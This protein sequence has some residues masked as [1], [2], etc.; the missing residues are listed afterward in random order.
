MKGKNSTLNKKDQLLEQITSSINDKYS[1]FFSS[2]KFYYAYSEPTS[3]Q[4]FLSDLKEKVDQFNH[5]LEGISRELEVGLKDIECP[6]EITTDNKYSSKGKKLSPEKNSSQS[7]AELLYDS[8]DFSEELIKKLKN[9]QAEADA[10][11]AWEINSELKALI[12]IPSSS[13][14]ETENPSTESI[15]DGEDSLNE[16]IDLMEKGGLDSDSDHD[17]VSAGNISRFD[18]ISNYKKFINY[19]LFDKLSKDEQYMLLTFLRDEITNSMT[20]GDFAIPE[21]SFF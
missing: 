3:L 5:D 2:I 15:L 1:K 7:S 21:E 17:S 11:I 13:N 16:I 18:F 4:S 14:S 19:E 9:I 8:R 12:S 6:N 10:K 20:V